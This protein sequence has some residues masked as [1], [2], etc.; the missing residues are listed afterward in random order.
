MCVRLHLPFSTE[1][2]SERL[3]AFLDNSCSTWAL[4]WG[5]VSAVSKRHTYSIV[6]NANPSNHKVAQLEC[7]KTSVETTEIPL[8]L[9][10]FIYVISE[11]QTH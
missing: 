5:H 1:T 2:T 10:R 7:R 3:R 8:L 9:L 11:N 6:F 4:A